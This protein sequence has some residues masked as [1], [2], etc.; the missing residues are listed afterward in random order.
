[1]SISKEAPGLTHDDYTVGWI[2][3]LPNEQ[4]VAIAMLDEEHPNL[5]K[6]PN[7][8]N[9]YTLGR[10]GKHNVVIA[11]LPKGQFGTTPTAVVAVWMR[12]TFPAIHFGMMVG[13]GQGIPPKVKL[14]DVVISSPVAE[15][16]GVIQWDRGKA[17]DGGKFRRTGALNNPPTA[18]LTALSKLETQQELE[19]T[20]IKSYMQSMA[21]RHPRLQHQYVSDEGLVDPNNE[22]ERLAPREPEVHCGLIAS[23]NQVIRDKEERDRIDDMCGGNVL[24]IETE[25]AALMNDFPCIVIRGIGGYADARKTNDWHNYAAA[26]A[27]ACAKELLEILDA[28]DV[29]GERE[30][31]DVLELIRLSPIRYRQRVPS[32]LVSLP[33]F[34]HAGSI[35]QSMRPHPTRRRLARNRMS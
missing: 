8:R 10:I 25:S 21:D 28:H 29:K 14:G 5:P 11:C 32:V 16:P 30:A 33:H 35:M 15:H 24:C 23:G 18:L 9:A 31:R 13:V 6:P 7:D 19:G 34:G 4:T 12:G 17:E 27:A 20:R 22:V 26:V 3:A 2:C 1:M